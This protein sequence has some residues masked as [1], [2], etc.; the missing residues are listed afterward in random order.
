M[1]ISKSVRW[2]ICWA[3]FFAGLFVVA[4]LDIIAQVAEIWLVGLVFAALYEEDR[5]RLRGV[6]SVVLIHVAVGL[7]VIAM[8][9]AAPVKAKD[10]LL[11]RHVTLP[12]AEM[13]LSELKALVDEEFQSRHFPVPV[14]L[15]F[16]PVESGRVVRWGGH[17]MTLR[18]FLAAI[19]G[20]TRL[21]HEF[22]G[23]CGNATTILFGGNCGSGVFLFDPADQG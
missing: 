17:E 14:R 7:T 13:S 5:S 4:T 1:R 15:S 3:A 8:A 19:E 10:R 16:A 23:G 18:E 9:T 12:K 6:F 21:R 11:V 20:Q 22:G 2:H